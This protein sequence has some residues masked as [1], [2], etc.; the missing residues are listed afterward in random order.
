M[1]K[2][3]AINTLIK[4]GTDEKKNQNKVYQNIQEE[5]LDMQIRLLDNQ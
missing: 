1:Q 3:K 5:T 2:A 4:R